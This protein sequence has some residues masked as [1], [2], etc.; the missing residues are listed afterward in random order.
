[1]E[2]GKVCGCWWE[3]GEIKNDFGGGVGKVLYKFPK[4]RSGKVYF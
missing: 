2:Q 4:L 1:M 3:R